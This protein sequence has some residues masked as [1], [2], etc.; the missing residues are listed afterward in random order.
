MKI[1]L[2]FEIHALE[3][4]SCES[5]SGTREICDRRRKHDVPD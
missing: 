1:I 3:K 4:K 5:A 2:E